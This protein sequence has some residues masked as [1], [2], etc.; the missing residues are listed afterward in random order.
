MPEADDEKAILRIGAANYQCRIWLNGKLVARHVGGHTPFSVDITEYLAEHNHLILEVNNARKI[1]QVPSV[2]YDWKNYGGVHRDVELFQVPKSYI[3]DFFT[4]LVPGSG[5][6]RIAFEAEVSGDDS[7]LVFSIPE[8]H[9]SESVPVKNHKAAIEIPA[10][11]ELWSP[12]NPRLYEV[13]VESESD[14]VCDL[15]GYREIS[16]KGKELY[17]N[18]IPLYLKGVCCHEETEESGRAIQDDDRLEMLLR[19]KKMGCNVIRLVH[20]PHSEKMAKLADR[21]GILLWEEIPVYWALCFND[22]DTAESAN[23]QMSELVLRDR[24]RASVVLWSIGNENPDTDDRYAFMSRLADT[25]R[26]LDPSRLITAACLV[27]IDTMKV[28]DRLTS[29]V[30]VVAINE[31][32]GWY[33]RDYG[34]L[35]EI[36]NNSVMDKPLVISETGADAF[37]RH[38]GMDEELYTEEHQAKM[39]RRQIE[40]TDGRIQGFFPWVLYDF[41]SDIRMNAFQQKF[42]KKGLVSFD[43]THEK[44]AFGVIREYYESR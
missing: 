15:V 26:A 10:R 34:G 21:E 14:R 1:N 27:D 22:P 43:R 30:D 36:L 11:P 38:H 44:M 16:R 19:A 42:N 32:Y 31:Y 18:G 9:V 6:G 17:L 12:D 2:N 29:V 40:M 5:F 7:H 28:K 13:V 3:V 20:Y 24:N 41:R 4:Y 33:Y 39:Y 35:S 25:V 37:P 8:L 23:N